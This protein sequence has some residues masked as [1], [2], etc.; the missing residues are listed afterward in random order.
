MRPWRYLLSAGVLLIVLGVLL[1][2]GILNSRTV[3]LG[4]LKDEARSF[5]S[6]VA[7]TQENSI[8]GEAKFE[9]E[10]IGRIVTGVRSL[11]ETGLD[12]I[13]MDRF[14]RDFGARSIQ[15]FS[16]REET[17]FK[18][19]GY[20]SLDI[21]VRLPT[22][23]NLAYDYAAIGKEKIIRIQLRTDR[24][25]YQIDAPASE[26]ENF[27]K[28][29]GVNR[30]LSQLTANPMVSYLVLQ[31]RKG[32]I[33]ATPNIKTI[34][35]IES[36]SLLSGVLGNGREASR[37][38]EF[39][40]KKIMEMVQPFVIEGN[41]L[42]VFRIGIGLDS[43]YHHVRQTQGQ[44]ILLFVILF[45]IGTT[46]LISSMRLQN[47]FDREEL[48]SKTLGAID[49]GVIQVNRRGAIT[50]VNPVFCQITGWD[51]KRVLNKSYGEVLPDDPFDIG[52][53]LKNRAK[54]EAEK[55]IF[56]K[57]LQYGAYPLYDR[58]GRVSGVIAIIRDVSG[59][60]KFEK[61]RAEA[62]RLSFLGNLVANFAHEIKNPLNGLSIATQRLIKEFPATDDEQNQLTAG[63]KKGI[64]SLN[65]ILNDFL[66]LA[67]PRMKDNTE[68]EVRPA[69][70]E[71]FLITADR[72]KESHIILKPEISDN[73][74]LHGN[75]E[76][77]KRAILNILL[78]A[79]DAV[80]PINNREKIIQVK[81]EKSGSGFILTVT[82]N[83]IGMD[84][85]EQNRI[86]TPYFTTKKSGTGLGLYIAQKIIKDHGGRVDIK[87]QKNQGTT[88]I[89]SFPAMISGNRA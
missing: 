46:G 52:G 87:S 58:R 22:G 38:A 73:V 14:L 71:I 69:L 48:F 28:E 7:L 62:D 72:L 78:N 66:S 79:A 74:K 40:N 27:R 43:Y 10:V 18:K 88:F 33:L 50:G 36:D 29:F 45:V 80:S 70:E 84:E 23:E 82:D 61:E 64:D 25:T 19:A 3:M 11:E 85:E 67:R 76:D 21:L 34:N 42:G 32:I 5:L 41:V 68:F 30:I 9:D 8:F 56:D 89:I 17:M 4:L 15:V 51:E 65:K 75:S 55:E 59:L 60:R 31:D 37:I 20:P 63:I 2:V 57:N 86:F 39:D 81:I 12:Q 47:Y 16:P 44:L 83:G 77:F 6:L 1:V 26:I 35:R 53:V 24:Y 49:E 54:V 13:G